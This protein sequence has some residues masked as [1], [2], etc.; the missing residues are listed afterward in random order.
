MSRPIGLMIALASAASAMPAAAQMTGTAITSKPP[1]TLRQTQDETQ[2]VIYD[3][4]RCTAQRA[5][6]MSL[7]FIN[8]EPGAQSKIWRKLVTYYS[9]CIGR[10]SQIRLD[11]DIIS[12]ALANGLFIER[13]ASQPVP[14]TAETV[15]STRLG[16]LGATRESVLNAI[17]DCVVRRDWAGSNA[18]LQTDNA[19]GAEGAA[20]RAL[21]PALS[22]CFPAGSQLKIDKLSLRAAIAR[23]ALRA[24]TV[25]PV[26]A[27]K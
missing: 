5:P 2:W 3:A 14:F 19:K 17:G 12:G 7:A 8:A 20:F 21:A 18:L 13:Y 16:E 24:F 15:S 10:A 6:N 11:F 4:A 23:A 1:V 27:Q 22:A 9:E 25:S 26:Q